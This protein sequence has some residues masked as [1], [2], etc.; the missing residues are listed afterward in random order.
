MAV[1]LH[2]AGEWRKQPLTKSVTGFFVQLRSF[3]GATNDWDFPNAKNPAH[4]KPAG[5]FKVFS[6]T[7]PTL[8]LHAM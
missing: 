8:V 1:G 4:N 2:K 5:S 3:T 7:E 6:W